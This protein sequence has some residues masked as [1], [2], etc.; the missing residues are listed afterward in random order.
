MQETITQLPAKILSMALTRGISRRPVLPDRVTPK[1]PAK[2]SPGTRTVGAALGEALEIVQ[3]RTH[4]PSRRA[5]KYL[6]AY[7]L[8]KPRQA[9]KDFCS[10]CRLCRYICKAWT[11]PQPCLS[12]WYVQI[13]SV[14]ATYHVLNLYGARKGRYISIMYEIGLHWSV[15]A[16]RSGLHHIRASRR[17]RQLLRASTAWK[18]GVEEG[19]GAFLRPPQAPTAIRKEVRAC[20]EIETP[21]L[22]TSFK[23]I[24]E[25]SNKSFFDQIRPH[26]TGHKSRGVAHL[27]TA[28]VGMERIRAG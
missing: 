24:L 1:P 16:A 11:S 28:C 10:C 2:Y 23:E 27:R 14:G 25:I 19:R 20:P 5:W 12:T 18:R 15:T 7:V 4:V 26:E 17:N 22:H 9:R 8:F 6:R 13:R 21:Q 3:I